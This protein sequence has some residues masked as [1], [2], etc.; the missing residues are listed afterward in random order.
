[1]SE[2][3]IATKKE[4][5]NLFRII[6]LRSALKLEIAGMRRRGRSAYSI[7]KEEFNL[8]GNMKSVLADVEQLI[9][10]KKDEKSRSLQKYQESASTALVPLA[11]QKNLLKEKKKG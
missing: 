4:D 2:G 3:F 7:L 9:A 8:I 10:Q 5:I 1:M 11:E 6:T